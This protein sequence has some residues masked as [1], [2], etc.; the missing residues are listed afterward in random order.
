M[1]DIAAL[2]RIDCLDLKGQH[3]QIRDE[4][5]ALWGEVYAKTAFS[6]GPFVAEFENVFAR[7]CDVSHAVACNSGTSA[8]HLALSAL[9]IGKG[10]EVIVPANTFIA[11]AWSV[12]YVGATIVFVDCLPDTWQLDPVKVEQAVTS[13]TK[14]IIGVHLYGQPFDFDAIESIARARHIPIIEDSAQ[15]HGAEYKG[16]KAGSMGDLA[17]FSFYPGKNLGACGEGGAVVTDEA[18][19]AEHLRA[20]RNHGCKERYLHDELGFNMRMGGLEATSLT[21][22][23]KYLERWNARRREIAKMYQ[24]GISNPKVG[25]Q[26]QPEHT[27]SVYHLFVI[28]TDDRDAMT[29][30]LNTHNI[31][32]ALHY[33]VPCHLQKAY[34]WMRHAPGDFPHSEHLAAHCLSLPMYPELADEEIAR[35]VDAVNGC[36]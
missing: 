29:R 21:V 28:T 24:G 12:T 14:A 2:G 25:M 1:S 7:H 4:V 9:R 13:R 30:H 18:G 5:F 16:R 36:R 34:S 26:A 32:P 19:W 33:P 6:G 15:A 35:V 27:S 22:K 17:C 8:L 23:L 11:T 3:R 20:L 31:W 10:D